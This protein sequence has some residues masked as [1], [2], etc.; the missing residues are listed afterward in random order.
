MIR[1]NETRG[2]TDHFI[3]GVLLTYGKQYIDFFKR[4]MRSQPGT[5][6]AALWRLHDCHFQQ[7]QFPWTS[8]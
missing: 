2:F 5:A 6:R 3:R 7:T 4:V 8:K 1:Y